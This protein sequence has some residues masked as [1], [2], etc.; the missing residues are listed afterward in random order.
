MRWIVC[1]E[2][3]CRV[4]NGQN[5]DT[6]DDIG[7]HNDHDKVAWWQKWRW[8]KGRGTVALREIGGFIEA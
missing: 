8:H 5:T 7:A 4:D 3:G 6:V 1:R 2:E